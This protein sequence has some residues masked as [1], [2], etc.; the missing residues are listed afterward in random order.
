MNCGADFGDQ[1]VSRPLLGRIKSPNEEL[2]ISKS[3]GGGG[4]DVHVLYV[5][6]DRTSKTDPGYSSLCSP[7]IPH[8]QIIDTS[9]APRCLELQHL[10]LP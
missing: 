3:V 10:L 2:A 9:L 7:T 1:G 5:L 8:P 6:S 4:V